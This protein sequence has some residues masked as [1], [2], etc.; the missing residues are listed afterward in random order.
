MSHKNHGSKIS[1]ELSGPKVTR[2]GL[3]G[4]LVK[5]VVD[6]F[7]SRSLG[8]EILGNESNYTPLLFRVFPKES[9]LIYIHN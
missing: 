4:K 8:S 1:K 5:I 9:Q 2:Y 6:Q 7:G 3:V